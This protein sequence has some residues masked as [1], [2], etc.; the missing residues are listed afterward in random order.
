MSRYYPGDHRANGFDRQLA[1]PQDT[2]VEQN[3]KELRESRV[4]IEVG[5]TQYCKHCCL[6]VFSV[7]VITKQ[8]SCSRKYDR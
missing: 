2:V 8:N 5:A 1:V 4:V 3:M 6:N 7:A